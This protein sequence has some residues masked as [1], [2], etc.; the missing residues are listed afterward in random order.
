MYRTK[1]NIERGYAFV[2]F[3]EVVDTTAC[4][5]LDGVMFNG[6]PLKVKRPKDYTAPPGH[7][8]PQPLG[9][10]TIAALLAAKAQE[11]SNEAVG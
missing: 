9:A 2:E 3:W 11:G 8:D 1:M 4:L 6:S 7:V 10:A 5:A